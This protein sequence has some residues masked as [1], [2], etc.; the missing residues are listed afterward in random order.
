MKMYAR[1]DSGVV[2]EIIKPMV[3]AEGNEIPIDRRFTAEFV[4][5]LVDI[6]GMNPMP[7]E[8]WLYVDGSFSAPVN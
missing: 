6:S 1:I 8:W 7:Q 5:T 2:A 3:D 4:D